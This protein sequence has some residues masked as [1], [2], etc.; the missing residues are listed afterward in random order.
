MSAVR[1]SARYAKSLIDLAIEQNKLERVK[2]DVEYF[3]QASRVRD[4]HLLLKS[5]IVHTSTK[6]KVFGKLSPISLI[7]FQMPSS[8]SSSGKDVKLTWARSRKHSSS[9]TA[10]SRKSPA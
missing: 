3:H 1:L 5:P 2:E 4:L 10:R 7:N 6:R 8:I 9:N